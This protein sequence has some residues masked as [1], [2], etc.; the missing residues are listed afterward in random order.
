M[1]RRSRVQNGWGDVPARSAA[2]ARRNEDVEVCAEGPG[3]AV[4]APVFCRP[5][6]AGRSK[7]QSNKPAGQAD[8]RAGGG[9]HQSDVVAEAQPAPVRSL[10]GHGPL[11]QQHDPYSGGDASDEAML[12][13]AGA[14]SLE[15][16]RDTSSLSANSASHPASTCEQDRLS[17]EAEDNMKRLLQLSDKKELRAHASPDADPV[18]LWFRQDLRLIDNPALVT[19]AQSGRPV[20]PVYLHVPAE[21]GRW[22]LGGATKFWLHQALTCLSR[23]LETQLGSKLLVY[24][25]DSSLDLLLS[26][27]VE[28]RASSVCFNRV[29]E[30][31]KIKRDT[32]IAEVLGANGVTVSS[33]KGVVLFEP[34]E[35]VPDR[36]ERLMYG[37]GSVGFFLNACD[38]H[39]IGAPLPAPGGRL[40]APREWPLA[41]RVQDLRLDAMPLRPDGTTIDWAGGIREFWGFG[42]AAAH[43]ALTDFV[44]NGC[45]HFE[46]KQRFR[47]DRKYTSVISPYVRFGELSPRTVY[48]AVV[49]R[50]RD[51]A[52]TF[53][54]RLAWRDLAYWMLWKLPCMAEE[55]IRPQ[56][57]EQWWASNDQHLRAWQRG[58]T[59]YPLVDA[60]MRQLW[61]TGW[62]PNYM[63]HVVAGFLIEH[64]NLHWIH[65]EQWFHD[66]LV[67]ADVAIN[68]Y[69]WQNGGHS[70]VDQWNF[71]MH[72][73][74]AAKSCDPDGHFVRKWCPELAKLPAEYIHCPWEAP[75]SMLAAAGVALGR[76]YPR[77]VI[78]DLEAG[79]KQALD[80]VIRVRQGVGKAFIL[81]DGNE[82]LR[83]P[84]GR[85]VRLITRVDYREMANVPLTKQTA[86]ETRDPRRRPRRD[87]MSVALAD[88]QNAYDRMGAR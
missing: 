7:P 45:F 52:R 63:R 87:P 32:E 64:L 61:A 68:A 27:I 62:M 16:G 30:P 48:A 4:G 72:P 6:R 84:D 40:R 58:Y 57:A 39:D 59:G 17:L 66:T 85:M 9:P 19:A 86:D 49:G 83:L 75:L 43:A 70:G 74:F 29:Y 14:L 5:D 23:S 35:V 3:L 18:I 2:A 36:T 88:V 56:Y 51:K 71:V 34:V 44:C 8:V 24:S 38:G 47:A 15:H 12:L 82:S 33:C 1:P 13:M 20:L 60:A 81:P 54:R 78:T 67:D 28:T 46:G 11:G 80:A 55:P 76:S 73:V 77:R 37:F 10:D 79:R 21:E 65:G 26:L 41:Q 22:P 31:W 53:L 42:E 69:M 50:H 25:G